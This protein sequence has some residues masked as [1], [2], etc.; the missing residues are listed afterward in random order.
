MY[1]NMFRALKERAHCFSIAF[2]S[3]ILILYL[4]HSL[5]TVS[6]QKMISNEN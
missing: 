5:T 2:Y 4:Y 3:N 6:R 1:V